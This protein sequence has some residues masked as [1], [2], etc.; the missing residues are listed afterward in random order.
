MPRRAVGRRGIHPMAPHRGSNIG[1]T[2]LKREPPPPSHVGVPHRLGAAVHDVRDDE[3]GGIDVVRICCRHQCIVT[4]QI[5]RAH[6]R[7]ALD[8]ALYHLRRPEPGSKVRGA[9]QRGVRAIENVLARI[10][11]GR[12]PEQPQEHASVARS[13]RPVKAGVTAVVGNEGVTSGSHEHLYS[14]EVS[15]VR[16][17]QRGGLAAHGAVVDDNGGIA[18]RR[19]QRAYDRVS[20][21]RGSEV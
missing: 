8:Q 19:E 5:P 10:L 7:P 3:R 15:S 13:T 1:E 6:V 9:F 14:G 21:A 16:G 18:N 12:P 4:E 11:L 2:R 20:A 17:E